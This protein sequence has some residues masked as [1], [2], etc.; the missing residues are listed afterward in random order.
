M[1]YEECTGCIS[2][3]WRLRGPTSQG[4]QARR[5]ASNAPTKFE[6]AINLKTAE[7]LGLTMAPTLLDR[8][9]QVIE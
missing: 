6:L 3:G 9:D 5:S 4:R 7:T 2:S 1:S 8:A